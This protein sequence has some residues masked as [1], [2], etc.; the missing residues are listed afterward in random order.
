[1][2]GA[3]AAL[4]KGLGVAMLQ[5]GVADFLRNLVKHSP[6][7]R[8][9]ERDTLLS[10]LDS[11]SGTGSETEG[12]DQIVGIVETM[13]ETMKGDLDEAIST[14]QQAKASFATLETTKAE[15]IAAAAKAVQSKTVRSGE[16]AVS[17]TESKADLANTEKTLE[18]DTK[19]KAELAATCKT[20]QAEWDE[21]S[22]LRSEELAALSETVAM[23][24]DDDALDLFKKTMPSTVGSMLQ[25]TTNKHAIAHAVSVVKRLLA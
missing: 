15:E 5:T 14:E 1:M 8:D 20:K 9:D 7:V 22:K 24:N 18:K 4:K 12:S 17:I 13:K 3:V 6:A 23:L 21:R 10:F 25:V 19:F 16:V 2:D 11:S